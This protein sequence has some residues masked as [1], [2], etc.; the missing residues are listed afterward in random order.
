MARTL[1]KVGNN[2]FELVEVASMQEAIQMVA[3]LD[4]A[5]MWDSKKQALV[6]LEMYIAFLEEM[7]A[8]TPMEQ[9]REGGLWKLLSQAEGG[10]DFTYYLHRALGV[11]QASFLQFTFTEGKGKE[12]YEL[13]MEKIIL[14]SYRIDYELMRF[15]EKENIPQEK[16]ERELDYLHVTLKNHTLRHISPWEGDRG[17]VTWVG[18][19]PAWD[20][21]DGMRYM[22]YVRVLKI[23]MNCPDILSINLL[24]SM[25]GAYRVEWK[26]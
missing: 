26:R 2:V 12:V 23:L 10:Y 11:L 17:F 22:E 15:Y 18:D 5:Q 9:M 4:H 20:G 25:D 1:T 19:F 7:S 21:L 16:R 14:G 3:P 24:T 13:F 8:K 6:P